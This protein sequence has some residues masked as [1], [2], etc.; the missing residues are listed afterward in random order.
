MNLVKYGK[1]VI[2]RSPH[3]LTFILLSRACF[4][5]RSLQYFLGAEKTITPLW[6]LFLIQPRRNMP[7]RHLF[8][9]PRL[10]LTL[11]FSHQLLAVFKNMVSSGRALLSFCFNL[12]F[13]F[14]SFFCSRKEIVNWL[15]VITARVGW[16]WPPKMGRLF[17]RTHLMQGLML[18]SERSFLRCTS[19]T[20]FIPTQVV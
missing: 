12:L 5:W 15:S 18:S 14:S 6:I 1:I 9:H 19:F 3:L 7:Q 13:F 11:S 10:W 8:S 2:L 4:G 20:Y 17:V 16:C